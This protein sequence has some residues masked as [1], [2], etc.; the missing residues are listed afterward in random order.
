MLEKVT[1]ETK[2][3]QTE[4]GTDEAQNEGI[5]KQN[6]EVKVEENEEIEKQNEENKVE[7]NEENINKEE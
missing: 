4:I 7:E 2:E 6:E 5:E 1:N 3:E